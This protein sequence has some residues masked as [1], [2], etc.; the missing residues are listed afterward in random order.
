VLIGEIY[1]PIE[2]VI[3]YYG[4]DGSGVHLPFNF[5]LLLLPWRAPII[6]EAIDQ[7]EG[8]L[9]AQAWPNWV[10][11]NHDKPRIATRVGPA[12]ARVAAMLLLTLRGTPT[13]YYGDE[14][15]MRNVSVPPERVQDP[16][17]KNMPGLGFGR[18]PQ[19]APMPWE[20]APYAGFSTATPWLPLADDY[21]HINVGTQQADAR[22]MLNLHRRLIAL[23]REHPALTV[24][25]Y[26]PLAAEGGMIVFIRETQ[27]ERLLVALNLA[28]VAATWELP[29]AIAPEQILLST[30]L[31]T[32]ASA[33]RRLPLRADEGMVIALRA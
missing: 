22:S 32:P 4:T 13:L 6:K 19:R 31:D 12:Q 5:Q 10:L 18:D 20:P 16:L 26:V 14:L 2:R 23:R 8:A 27:A 21:A 9:P 33:G 25:R 29:A 7:Y 17:E 11:G 1:L 28:S 15:G 3:A 30:Y 24:G